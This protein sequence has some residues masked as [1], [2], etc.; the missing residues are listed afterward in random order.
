M[1]LTRKSTPALPN[2]S[3]NVAMSA[4]STPEF[5]AAVVAVAVDIVEATAGCTV[6][7][8]AIVCL[9]SIAACACS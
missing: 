3:F 7:G 6:A 4:V 9:A 8:V 2:A 5:S 1:K